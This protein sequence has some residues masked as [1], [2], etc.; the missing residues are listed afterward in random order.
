VALDAHDERAVEAFFTGLEPVDH[1]VSLVGDSMSGGFLATTPDTMRHVLGSKFLTNWLIARHAARILRPGGSLTFTS[2]TGGRPHEVSA[3]YVANLAIQALVQ[4][5]AYE[6]APDRRVNAVAP[7]FMGT[8]TSFWRDIPTTEL[9]QLEAG[10]ADTVPLKRIAE[11]GEVAAAYLH[12]LANRF[13][14]GQVLAV[15]GGVMLAT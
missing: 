4:G 8:R 7:T 9:T 11:P 15:D 3:T 2:G 13:I 12:L 10:F 14:T 5:L 6:M 1:V